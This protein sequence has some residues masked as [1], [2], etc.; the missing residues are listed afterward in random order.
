MI[1]SHIYLRKKEMNGMERLAI[2]LYY[3]FKIS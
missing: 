3:I 2:L 1:R